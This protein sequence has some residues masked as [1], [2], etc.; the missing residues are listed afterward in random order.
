MQPIIYKQ[1]CA[2]VCLTLL[3]SIMAPVIAVASL[4]ASTQ[5]FDIP[6]DNSYIVL[7]SMVAVLATLLLNLKRQA[8]VSQFDGDSLRLLM[9]IVG[10][11][12]VLLCILLVIGYVTK[13]SAVYSR[14][15]LSMWSIMTPAGLILVGM[16]MH[17]LVRRVMFAS[18]NLRRVAFAGCTE[19]SVMLA[20]KIMSNP[21]HCMRVLGFF[22]DR[23]AGRLGCGDKI[24]RVGAL[25]DLPR[26]AREG[27]IDVLFIA[28]PI[29]QVKRVMDLLETLHDTT[30][31]IYYVPDIFAFDLIQARGDVIFGIPVVAM[32]ETPLYG[33]GGVI[34]RVTDIVISSFFLLVASPL[35]LAIAAAVKLS[36]KGPVI[37][38][39]RRYGLNGEE[40]LVYKFRTMTV[41]EDGQDVKQAT[42][43]DSRV[44]SVGRFLRQNS[45]DELPQLFNVLKGDMSLVGPRPHA[46]A[47]NEE[48]RKVIKGYMVRHKV[49]PGITGLAQIKGCRGETAR[50]EDMEARVSYDLEYL[51]HWSPVLDM[52]ILA[53]TLCRMFVDE[54]AY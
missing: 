8:L 54:K 24:K 41:T 40:I 2:I 32:C 42:K 27:G 49:L 48:Y 50:I 1:S 5:I 46:V 44:T 36:S 53:I 18:S 6:F 34:K 26:V 38:K 33:Y 17:Q 37:F 47:H 29:R 28:L 11:W 16:I 51:R 20:E 4:Y 7:S 13:S 22:D 15:V 30:V 21:G 19:L 3:Q 45:F 39:Q 31:S 35:F 10:N 14:R 25:T 23:S 12:F 43:N 52:K 9:R